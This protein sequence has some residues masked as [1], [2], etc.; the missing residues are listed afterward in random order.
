MITILRM[1]LINSLSLTGILLSGSSLISAI[2][3]WWNSLH[4]VLIIYILFFVKICKVNWVFTWLERFLTIFEFAISIACSNF[5]TWQHSFRKLGGVRHN[6]SSVH[7]EIILVWKK[8]VMNVSLIVRF[9]TVSLRIMQQISSP[10]VVHS[11]IE[12]F[13]SRFV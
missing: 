13:I 3:S 7:L 8:S 11:I 9:Y 2:H 5:G 6:L 1:S 12:I 10:Y 4:S